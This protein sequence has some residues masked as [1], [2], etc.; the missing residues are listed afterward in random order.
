MIYDISDEKFPQLCLT[1]ENAKDEDD[2]NI[3]KSKLAAKDLLIHY[4]L[5]FRCYMISIQKVQS[6]E[7]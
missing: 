7:I 3:I 5:S 1:P 6:D 2:I 4:D